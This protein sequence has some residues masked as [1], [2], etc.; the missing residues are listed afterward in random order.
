MSSSLQNKTFVSLPFYQLVEKKALSIQ[1]R[2]STTQEDLFK[3]DVHYK[4]Y[5]CKMYPLKHL[6]LRSRGL[7][8]IEIYG[9]YRRNFGV[10]IKLDGGGGSRTRVRRSYTRASTGLGQVF[11]FIAR[12]PLTW[13]S[14]N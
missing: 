14:D 3:N 4:N 5:T 8:S 11:M 7:G 10:R 9:S 6:N 2:F 12:S 13:V 1:H